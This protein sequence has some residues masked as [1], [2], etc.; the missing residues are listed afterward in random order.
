MASSI[1]RISTKSFIPLPPFVGFLSAPCICAPHFGHFPH[2]LPALCSSQWLHL[3]QTQ[4][5]HVPCVLVSPPWFTKLTFNNAAA[6][7][8]SSF[9]CSAVFILAIQS[10]IDIVASATAE[11][12]SF[13]FSVFAISST[14]PAFLISSPNKNVVLS[15]SPFISSKDLP[16]RSIYFF[17]SKFESPSRVSAV[18]CIV[19]WSPIARPLALWIIKTALSSAIIG[20]PTIAIYEAIDAASPI[21][22]VVIFPSWFFNKLKISRPG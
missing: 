19:L 16:V 9:S 20:L 7:S 4:Y 22:L 17:A 12:R 5:F 18:L 1:A 11:A 13:S 15:M 2:G 14:K 21:S 8:R 10:A 6:F 3:S